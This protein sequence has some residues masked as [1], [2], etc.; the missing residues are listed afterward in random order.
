MAKVQDWPFSG[1]GRYVRPSEVAHL[2]LDAVVLQ[3]EEE[4]E[5]VTLWTGRRPGPDL[6][7]VLMEHHPPEHPPWGATRHYLAGRDDIPIVHYSAHNELFWDCGDAP[8][9][10]IE[11]GC[12][13]PGYRYSGRMR[14][15]GIATNSM[16]RRGRLVGTDLLPP[17]RAIAPCD[18]F[19]FGNEQVNGLGDRSPEQLYDELSQRR[20]YCHPMRWGGGGIALAEAM[21]LGMPVLALATTSVPDWVPAEAGLVTDNVRLFVQNAKDLIDDPGRCR[22]MGWAAREVALRRFGL[23]R[24]HSEWT[25]LLRR[26]VRRDPV[27]P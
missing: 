18:I 27:A 24:F 26:V 7:A 23:G 22:D 6:P 19:G 8:T 3:R 13:D 10:V 14:H 4:I 12:P 16:P 21:H 11:N 15:F 25:S 2:V 17:L 9:H 1:L 20:V 5:W